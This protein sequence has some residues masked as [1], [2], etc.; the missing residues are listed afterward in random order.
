[1]TIHLKLDAET[2]E[3]LRLMCE[4]EECSHNELIN[5][6]ILEDLDKGE[7]SEILRNLRLK[8]GWGF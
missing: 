5:R 7:Q 6:L 8:L 3:R 4:W 2:L 1:M